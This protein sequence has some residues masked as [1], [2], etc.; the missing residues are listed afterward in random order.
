MT[1]TRGMY[2]TR[3]L[4]VEILG[5][6]PFVRDISHDES[7]VELYASFWESCLVGEVAGMYLLDLERLD[8][9]AMGSK[10]DPVETS[11]LTRY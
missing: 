3:R 4:D 9:P 10:L 8:P 6:V 5:T 11:S 1:T 7:A 2:A